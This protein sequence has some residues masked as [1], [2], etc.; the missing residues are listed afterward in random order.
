MAFLMHLKVCIACDFELVT[1]LL[2]IKIPQ[3]CHV[4]RVFR[5]QHRANEG[6]NLLLQETLHFMCI[7]VFT[8]LMGQKGD[9]S[10][11]D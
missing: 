5:L 10:F 7:C 6:T 8:S 4:C 9:Q 1:K 3:K 11:I 2:L